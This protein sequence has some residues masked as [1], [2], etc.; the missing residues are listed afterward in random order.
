MDVVR[1]LSWTAESRALRGG[2]SPSGL[3]QQWVEKRLAENEPVGTSGLLDEV[4][5]GSS[6]SWEEL[7]AIADAA[8]VF[9]TAIH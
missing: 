2:N 6:W 4:G 7:H 9:L 5:L 1:S 8:R 3:R